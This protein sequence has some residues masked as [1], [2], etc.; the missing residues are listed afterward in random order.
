MQSTTIVLI[1]KARLNKTPK[2]RYA[3]LQKCW[4]IGLRREHSTRNRRVGLFV[5]L[6]SANLAMRFFNLSKLQPRALCIV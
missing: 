4:K 5:R 1:A 6:K 3:M 2:I